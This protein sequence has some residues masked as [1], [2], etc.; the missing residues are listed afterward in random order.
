M[1]LYKVVLSSSQFQPKKETRGPLPEGGETKFNAYK[2]SYNEELFI[3]NDTCW[4]AGFC[5][6]GRC[7]V[8]VP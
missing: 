4:F 5:I 2:A 8:F 3:L 6:L 1:P 7:T